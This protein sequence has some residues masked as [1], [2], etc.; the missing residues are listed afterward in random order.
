MKLQVQKQA[1]AASSMLSKNIN[2]I[3]ANEIL[4][5]ADKDDKWVKYTLQRLAST[6]VQKLQKIAI[7][8]DNSDLNNT[9]FRL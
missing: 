3:K 8:T 2:E 4:G 1:E 5:T 6:L 7:S 9:E